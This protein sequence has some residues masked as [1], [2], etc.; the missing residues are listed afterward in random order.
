MKKLI[1]IIKN[2]KS[3]DDIKHFLVSLFSPEEVVEFEKRLKIIKQL[4]K[5]SSQREVAENLKVGIATVSRG[6][7]ELK[8]GHFKK[9]LKYI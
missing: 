8:K 9:I 5:G 4:S 3:D 2:L 7:K 6:A 1:N